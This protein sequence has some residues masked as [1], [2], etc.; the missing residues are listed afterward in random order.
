[1]LSQI[2]LVQNTLYELKKKIKERVRKSEL[3][4]RRYQKSHTTDA[5]LRPLDEGSHTTCQIESA[6]K[7]NRYLNQQT[8]KLK[9]QGMSW[10]RLWLK[11]L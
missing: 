1:M 4:S 9:Y 7:R 2:S 5:D 11:Q 3:L 8:V 6:L 10:G